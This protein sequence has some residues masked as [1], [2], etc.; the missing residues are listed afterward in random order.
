MAVHGCGPRGG[1]GARDEHDDRGD[2]DEGQR[3]EAEMR[4][5]GEVAT[6][7]ASGERAEA[8]LEFDRRR[9]ADRQEAW[10]GGYA[11][12][13]RASARGGVAG[14]ERGSKLGFEWARVGVH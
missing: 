13:S 9:K 4:P 5:S 8:A 3:E 10:S 14:G 6:A 1:R 12:A 7:D 2:D 11:A